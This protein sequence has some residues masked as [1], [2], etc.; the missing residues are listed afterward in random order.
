MAITKHSGEEPM[1]GK[2]DSWHRPRLEHLERVT[3]SRGKADDKKNL[4]VKKENKTNHQI[5]NTIACNKKVTINV[6][7]R[8]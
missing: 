5:S 2:E 6:K 8:V 7:L 4:C 1:N 3:T